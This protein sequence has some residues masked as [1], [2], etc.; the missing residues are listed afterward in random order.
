MVH[1][2]LGIIAIGLTLYLWERFPSF[3]WVL[4]TLVAIPIILLAALLYADN[5]K[6]L[7]REREEAEFKQRFEVEQKAAEAQKQIQSYEDLKRIK[8]S[9]D[10][11]IK[12]DKYESVEEKQKDITSAKQLDIW[13]NEAKSKVKN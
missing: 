7:E 4:A 10:I 9:I 2:V 6:Q 11:R 1:I 13:V 5:K 3:K 12:E 8:E